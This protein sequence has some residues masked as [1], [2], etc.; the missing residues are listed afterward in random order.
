MTYGALIAVLLICAGC[1]TVPTV[2]A[3]A[4]QAMPVPAQTRVLGQATLYLSV[5][6]ERLE[7]VHDGGTGVAIVKL[8]DER[9]TILPA[10]IAGAEG[11]YRDD[12]LMLWETDGGALLW[13][14]GVL[15]FTGNVAK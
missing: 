13:L 10:E 8:P 5:S 14:D 4:Q 12:H 1:A 2:S 6:G 3:P 11:R 15:V 9:L 7:V